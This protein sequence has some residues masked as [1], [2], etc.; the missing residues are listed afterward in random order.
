LKNIALHIRRRNR[1]SMKKKIFYLTFTGII[2]TAMLAAFTT[3]TEAARTEQKEQAIEELLYQAGQE[4]FNALLLSMFPID[5]TAVH[6]LYEKRGD[7][8]AM[9]E[10]TFSGPELID[11]VEKALSL[12]A[13]IDRVFLGLDMEKPEDISA[14]FSQNTAIG[15]A[16]YRM[17]SNPLAAMELTALAKEYPSVTFEVLLSCPSMEYL[18]SEKA[19]TV[20][21]L[22]QWYEHAGNL[23]SQYNDVPNIHVFMP[24]S[25]EWLICNG[26]NYTEGCRLNTDITSRVISHVFCDYNYIVTPA[27]LPEKMGAL[28]ELMTRYQDFETID[29]S[30]YTYV[31][32]GDSVIGNYTDTTSIPKVVEYLTGANTINYGY[33]GLSAAQ[34]EDGIGLADMI[35]KFLAEYKADTAVKD[36]DKLVFFTCFGINDYASG[37]TLKSDMLADKKAF[38]GALEYAVLM[39]KNAYPSCEVIL[40]TPNYISLNNH[41]TN[42]E[43][44]VVYEDF[45]NEVLGLSKELDLKCI[46]VYH[47]LGIKKENVEIYLDDECHPNEYGRLAFGKLITEHLEKWYFAA[48]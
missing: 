8:A 24:G 3:K 26:S 16:M 39:L 38:K 27:N 23:L 29:L 30:E 46:D 45:V 40:M 25:E 2:L 36:S 17:Y 18:Q 33:G 41:G 1:G 48:E 34:S 9:T 7:M 10:E 43:Y 15:N 28:R 37:R 42:A 6:V 4:E 13:G 11:T 19:S 20:S 21:G 22:F 5:P 35:D 44:G 32:F 47:D 14:N 12:H 31:F